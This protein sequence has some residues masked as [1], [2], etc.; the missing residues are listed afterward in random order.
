QVRG[1]DRLCRRAGPRVRPELAGQRL[2]ARGV[3]GEAQD[4][5]VAGLQGL[6]GAVSADSS[7]TDDAA[8]HVVASSR[9]AGGRRW[10]ARTPLRG[11]C[12]M[13]RRSMRSGRGS[14]ATSSVRARIRRVTT[15]LPC[16]AKL[17]SR[18]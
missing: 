11:T 17:A 2:E 15:R 5:F 14:A 9:V 6:A 7:G 1:L 16:N 13:P 3:A 4:D 10:I 8:S 18:L 12:V